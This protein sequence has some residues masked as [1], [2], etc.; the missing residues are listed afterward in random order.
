MFETFIEKLRNGTYITLETTPSRS[1]QFTPTI[2]KIATL[3]LDKLV[4]GFSTTD[5]PLAKLKYNALFAAMKLQDRFGLPTLATMS[6]RDR[7]RIAL[8]SDLLGANES[9]VRA[10][11]ALTGDSAHY[12][13]QPHAK[14]V[15]EGNSNLLLDIITTLNRGVDMADQKLLAPVQPIY[16]FAVIDAYAKNSAALQKKLSKKV[17]HGA[18]AIISQPVYD[19]ENARK[20]LTMTNEANIEHHANCVLILGYFPITKLR[21][22]RFLDENVPG[23]HVPHSWV[24]AL[25]AAAKISPEEEYRVGFELSKNL[26]EELKALHPKIHIMTANQFELAKAI[27][28]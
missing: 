20:L 11:L 27:L 8:Q 5:N 10:V 3:G 17:S 18:V 25:E 6:M 9:G 24:E 2:E 14:G 16:P 28:S 12:S 23:I 13:D 4:D 1:A 19:L 15:F 22:A 7:N 21:T 26:F